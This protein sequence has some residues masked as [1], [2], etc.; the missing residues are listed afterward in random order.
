MN[1]QDIRK[2]YP[3]FIYKD[4]SV[5]DYEGQIKVKYTFIQ[6]GEVP[7]E[8]CPEWI[9]PISFGEYQESQ[10]KRFSDIVFFNLGMAELISYWKACMS[11]RVDILCGHLTEKQIKWWK[12]LYFNGLGEFMYRNNIDLRIEDFMDIKA[13]SNGLCS[14][15][16]SK[17]VSG[18]LIPVGGGKDSAVT[19]E[20]LKDSKDTNHVY[21]IN[22]N[23]AA[24]LCAEAAGYNQGEIT[25]PVRKLD[26]KIIEMNKKGFL[27]GH[28]PF[29][30]VV[31]F[32]S[33]AAAALLG[34]KY[35]VL[36]NES[37][38]ND[39]YVK[40]RYV[41]HQYSKSLEFENDFRKY[42]AEFLS[43]KIEYFSLLR[44]MNEWNIIKRFVMHKKYLNIFKSCN[45][46]SK[47]NIWCL[48]CPKCL[49]TY[50]MLSPFL[51]EDELNNIFGRN[52]LDDEEMLEYFE[53]LV[54]ED[55]DKPFECIGTRSEI[56]AACTASV[57]KYGE[58]LPL[59]LKWYKD[60]YYNPD[61]DLKPVD[62]FFDE[63]N[64]IPDIFIKKLYRGQNGAL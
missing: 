7:T 19:L 40:E 43:D 10:N 29:S 30:S 49:F 37:S 25:T 45:L 2:K 42:T 64:N 20:T 44:C 1:F 3:Q 62:E 8:Y 15:D 38:A 57:R 52:L 58:N 61:Y 6:E 24:V 28:T 4:F 55:K 47:E 26:K 63:D 11:F 36:S 27:N 41:N 18:C 46:G 21:I 12:K 33:Y 23:K 51:N 39:S 34:K 56:N 14:S 16:Y 50:L 53:A 31:A 5:T 13:A 48:K 22:A 54:N 32:S 60:K 9:F 17:P 59:L 35:I